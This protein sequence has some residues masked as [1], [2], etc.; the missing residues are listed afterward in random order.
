MT[1]TDGYSPALAHARQIG[2]DA[3]FET[4][5]SIPALDFAEDVGAH[6]DATVDAPLTITNTPD[7]LRLDGILAVAPGTIG[8]IKACK[9]RVSNGT[10]YTAGR[11]TFKGRD[12][13]QHAHL[14]AEGGVYI[15]VVY[16]DTDGDTLSI[17]GAVIIT[18]RDLDR[19]LSGHWSDV[20]RH[21]RTMAKL[22]WPHLLDRT[23]I[24]GGDTT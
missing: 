24:N 18:A 23:T 16:K 15:L 2:D 12:D 11:W 10:G 13:G 6:H 1:R 17:L 21:E 8:E 20:D 7:W 4:I 22:G 3:E 14:L 5:T 19:L 9:H